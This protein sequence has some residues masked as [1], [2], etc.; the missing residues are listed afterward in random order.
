[1]SRL[2]RTQLARQQAIGKKPVVTQ[3]VNRGAVV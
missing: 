3:T 2:L 1:L